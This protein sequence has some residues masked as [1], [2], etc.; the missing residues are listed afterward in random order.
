MKMSDLH[1]EWA[2]VLDMCEGT[3]V[4][5]SECVRYSGVSGFCRERELSFSGNPEHYI[6]AISIL[7]GRPLFF[8]DE[9]YWKSSGSRLEWGSIKSTAYPGKIT[10]T[11]VKR[12]ITLNGEKLPAPMV[13]YEFEFNL[14]IRGVNGRVYNFNCQEDLMKVEAA[15]NK[16]LSCE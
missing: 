12:T 9:V 2:R 15:I 3:S 6:F 5:P 1:R 4:D 10:W 13:S 14:L 7:E 16:L 8:G 11:P